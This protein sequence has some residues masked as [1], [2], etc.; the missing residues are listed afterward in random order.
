MNSDVR[1]IRCGVADIYTPGN[2]KSLGE[3]IELNLW[4][5][6]FSYCRVNGVM[7]TWQ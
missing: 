5:F 4:A 2:R 6:I 1:R 7:L 3:I